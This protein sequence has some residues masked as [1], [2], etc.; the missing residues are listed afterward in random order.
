MAGVPRAGARGPRGALPVPAVTFPVPRR[1]IDVKVTRLQRL[2]RISLD[3]HGWGFV[4]FSR[5][6]LRRRGKLARPYIW[7]LRSLKVTWN[8][9]R[10]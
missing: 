4:L 2:W 5:M 7:R 1:R 10:W 9:P 6:R 8:L 3:G